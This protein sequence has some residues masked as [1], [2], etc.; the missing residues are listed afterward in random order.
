MD[1]ETAKQILIKNQS[2]LRTIMNTMKGHD[3][4][5]IK[6]REEIEKQINALE[7][8]IQLL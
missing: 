3:N 2:M 6:A 5:A 1:N 7:V 8:A 4:K